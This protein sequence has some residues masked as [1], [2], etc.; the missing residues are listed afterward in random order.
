MFSLW[1]H[2]KKLQ[3]AI[4]SSVM[5]IRK[6]HLQFA[7]VYRDKLQ[8]FFKKG[9]FFSEKSKNYNLSPQSNHKIWIKKINFFL[10]PQPILL[11]LKQGRGY[12]TIWV[13]VA[14]IVVENLKFID[15]AVTALGYIDLL[16]HK[17]FSHV[18]KLGLETTFLQQEMFL[19]KYNAVVTTIWIY[20][21]LKFFKRTCNCT[22]M[23][24][25]QSK[26]TS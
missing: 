8:I 4:L 22:T 12:V 9:I 23:Y 21:S 14:T 18:R 5:K 15:I 13:C 2:K 6:K 19:P 24:R 1:W 25:V 7:F 20:N 26:K 17:L 16:R 10:N 11:S 3:D